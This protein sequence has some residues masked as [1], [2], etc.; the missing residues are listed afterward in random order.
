[1]PVWQVPLVFIAV[2][3]IISIPSMIVAWLKLRQRTLGPILDAN[4][5][6]VNGRVKINIPFGTALTA[7][8]KLPPGSTHL[9]KDPY[10]DKEAKRQRRNTLLL[11]LLLILLGCAIWIR[12]DHNKRGHYFWQ[13]PP[14]KTPP[15]EPAAAPTAA[16]SSPEEKAKS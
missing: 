8:A 9:L 11:T 2:L 6:A 16:N 14:A 12:W 10:E 4:G 5:W 3:L 7:A 1:M 13:N 15:V